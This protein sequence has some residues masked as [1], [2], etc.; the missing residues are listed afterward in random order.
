MWPTSRHTLLYVSPDDLRGA[1]WILAS[2]PFELGGLPVA[3]QP[4][5]RTHAASAMTEWNAYFTT[6]VPHE[7]VTD[8]LV[9]LNARDMPD[10]DVMG[11]EA[12]LTALT[13]RGPDPG[14]GPAGYVGEFGVL[15]Q[16]LG[17]GCG[18]SLK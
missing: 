12:V 9:A 3:L 5:A 18:G 8:L 2:C 13:A 14:H 11:P 15:A 16:I 4:S 7:A 17:S 1:E 10:A 6:G